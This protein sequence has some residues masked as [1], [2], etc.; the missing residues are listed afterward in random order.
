M[1]MASLAVRKVQV[2]SWFAASPRDLQETRVQCAEHDHVVR[3]PCVSMST[4]GKLTDRHR[5]TAQGVYLLQHPSN[6]ERDPLTVR[7]KNGAAAPSVPAIGKDSIWSSGRRNNC[8]TP[9]RTPR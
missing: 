2:W 1:A 7:Q 9:S 5:D 4:P 8:V 6:L 3:G